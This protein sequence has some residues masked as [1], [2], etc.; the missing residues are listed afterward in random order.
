MR[1]TGK[2]K[3]GGILKKYITRQHTM[4]TNTIDL[5]THTI[6]SIFYERLFD[7]PTNVINEW[8]ET[9]IGTYNVVAGL[10]KEAFGLSLFKPDTID[11]E[12]TYITIN[13]SGNLEGIALTLNPFFNKR[14]ELTIC[15]VAFLCKKYKIANQYKVF[16]EYQRHQR[17]Y[18]EREG[19]FT[20]CDKFLDSIKLKNNPI[21]IHTKGILYVPMANRKRSNDNF[22]Y[23]MHNR[24]NNYYKIGRSTN[25]KIRERTLQAQEPDIVLI[26]KWQASKDAE[27]LLHEMYKHKKLR[28]EWFNLTQVE[29]EEIKEYMN[30]Y[31]EYAKTFNSEVV[32]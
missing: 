4:T 26:E 27:K 19:Y 24:Q 1:H 20:Y 28:G 31:V 7:I 17:S 15:F 8:A 10:E 30:R 5:D 22:I 11:Y 6:L 25:V 16:N 21:L 9:D 18:F 29:I 12:L 3:G 23:L 13:K 2:N 32:I 14:N